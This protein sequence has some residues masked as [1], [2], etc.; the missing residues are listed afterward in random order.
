MADEVATPKRGKGTAKAAKAAPP[1]AKLRPTASE[2]A[3]SPPEPQARAFEK[4]ASETADEAYD[5]LMGELRDGD[6]V[7]VKSS[8]AAGLRLLGDR[9]GESFS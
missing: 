8:N 2:N 4:A 6:R 7:L 3:D 5:Y 1:D 9:L